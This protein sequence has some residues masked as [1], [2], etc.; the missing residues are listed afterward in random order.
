MCFKSLILVTHVSY[1]VTSLFLKSAPKLEICPAVL[2]VSLSNKFNGNNYLQIMNLIIKIT[3][4]IDAFS[5]FYYLMESKDVFAV[6]R[7]S[8][9]EVT[10]V[11]GMPA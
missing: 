7:S 9:C 11:G 3:N 4:Y 10:S 1:N 2:A 5:L 6:G 8:S